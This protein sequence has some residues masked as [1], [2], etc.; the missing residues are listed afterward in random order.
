MISIAGWVVWSILMLVTVTWTLGLRQ[1]AKACIPFNMIT[2][3]QTLFFWMISAAFFFTTWN[4]LHI[5]WAAPCSLFLA[6][7]LLIGGM[8]VATPFVVMLTRIFIALITIGIQPQQVTHDS[9][10]EQE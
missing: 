3:V 8:P 9:T 10:N 5:L 6:Q 7:A 1:Y 4:K 2:A